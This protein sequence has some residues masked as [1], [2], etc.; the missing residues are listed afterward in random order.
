LE[1]IPEWL[2]D[3]AMIF[4]SLTVKGRM[5]AVAPELVDGKPVYIVLDPNYKLHRLSVQLLVNAYDDNSGNY[6]FKRWIDEGLLRFENEDKVRSLRT[7]KGLQLPSVVH[8]KNELGYKILYKFDL[9]K[10]R[11][12]QNNTLN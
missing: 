7:T 12:Q 10:Y 8:A 2:A 11:A 9:V 5:V 3:P 6:P 4:D 1:K